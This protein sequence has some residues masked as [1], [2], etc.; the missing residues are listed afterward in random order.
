MAD[1]DWR[2]TISPVNPAQAGELREHLSAQQVEE[3]VHRTLRGNV[4]VSSGDGR[5][6]L[7]ADSEA[8]AAEAQRVAGEH[9]AAHGI[10][11]S[12]ALH[13]WHPVAEEW[14]DPAVPLPSTAQEAAAEH[15]RLEESET[16]ESL[17]TGVDQWE[18]RAEFP[19][20]REAAAN[21]QYML[22]DSILVAPVVSSG[23]CS[24]PG[25]PA[26]TTI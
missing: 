15:E 18:A 23:N 2:V 5:I 24:N 12:F 9:L 16:A 4:A 8:A 10:Q 13:R 14:E 11:V 7:Y 26:S 21:D 6:Y 3:D 1:D 19:S 22:G 17:Q 25:T 20:H